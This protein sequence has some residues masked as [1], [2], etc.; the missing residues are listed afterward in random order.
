MLNKELISNTSLTNLLT[1]LK[2][3]TVAHLYSNY[4]L[5]AVIL[6]SDKARVLEPTPPY[7]GYGHPNEH[8]VYR[9]SIY[10]SS[11]SGSLCPQFKSW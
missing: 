6:L 1:T 11:A 9:V 7:P 4:Q 8:T 3:S 10:M 2:G 5:L